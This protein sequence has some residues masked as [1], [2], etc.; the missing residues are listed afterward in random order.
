[1]VLYLGLVVA[2]GLDEIDVVVGQVGVV[3]GLVLVAAGSIVKHYAACAVGHCVGV[4]VFS[5]LEHVYAGP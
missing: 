2:V 4:D 5:D 1:M 3:L